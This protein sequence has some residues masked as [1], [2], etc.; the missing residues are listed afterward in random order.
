MLKKA[1]IIIPA[2]MLTL[3]GCSWNRYQDVKDTD[4]IEVSQDATCELREKL[5]RI[6]PHN[7][8]IV[9][10][11]L[12]NVDNLNQ[13]SA[14]G[15]IV[16]DQI[17]SA[18]HDAGHEIIGMELPID[19][20]ILKD[21]GELALSDETKAQLRKHQ[22]AVLVGGVYA[23]G[24]KNTYVSLR[25]VDLFSKRVISTYDFSVPMGPDARLLLEPRPV[26]T[27]TPT[28]EPTETLDEAAKASPDAEAPLATPTER[29]KPE[30]EF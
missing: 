7:S 17:A 14:F 5:A 1:T 9:V 27:K 20:F 25:V 2:L 19:L 23:P 26:A 10:S 6:V 22:A 30:E 15:R 21:G 11:T 13:T 18:F 4:L 12:L 29:K 3:S 24:K 28:T 8:L 16:S